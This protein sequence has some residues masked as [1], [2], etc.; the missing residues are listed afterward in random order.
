MMHTRNMKYGKLG[1]GML[2]K[3]DSNL[4]KRM[5]HH[6]TSFEHGVKAIL[7]HNGFIWIYYD[8]EE[9]KAGSLLGKQEVAHHT[10]MEIPL[11]SRKWMCRVRNSMVNLNTH[12]MPIYKANIDAML[13]Y[14]KCMNEYDI[15]KN[16]DTLCDL[17]VKSI[18]N[19]EEVKMES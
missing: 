17:M 7:G 12:N 3:V 13:E 2:L 15:L 4:V 5:K 9:V 6:F 19:E 18:A 11:E 16:A 10:E 8:I 1:K 14:S